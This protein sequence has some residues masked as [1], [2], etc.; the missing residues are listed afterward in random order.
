MKQPYNN[1]AELFTREKE[2][3]DFVIKTTTKESPFLI[4]APHGG[5]IEPGTSEIAKMIAGLDYS[6]YLFEGIKKSENW[7]LHITSV[8]YDEPIAIQMIQRAD[9]AITVHGQ[10][11]IEEF[12]TIG[13]LHTE[14]K[15]ILSSN[16]QIA[17]FSLSSPQTENFPG[18][19]P[20]NVCNRGKLGRGIQLEI[21]QGLRNAL[22]NN[23][24]KLRLFGD[25]IRTTLNTF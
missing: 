9:T 1:F 5:H 8:L 22:V 7:K 11:G 21:S 25:I 24:E 20:L 18:L 13:G 16:L 19:N 15:N 10:E 23:K 3:I 2:G 6:L 14:L 17:G 12:L 4:M